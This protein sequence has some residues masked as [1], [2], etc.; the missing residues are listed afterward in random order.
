M[1][2]SAYV[3]II[4]LFGVALGF[5]VISLVTAR[6]A[7]PRRLNKAKLEPYE[8]GIEPTPQPVGGGRVP[9]KYYLTAMLFII[10]DIEV[11]FLVPWAVAA[12]QL[13]LGGFLAVALFIVA[14]TI[15]YIYEWRRGGLEWD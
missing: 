10:F 4:G 8:C 2:L 12:D 11:I 6:I 1:G 13:A 9:V 7:G 5:A 3:P 14:V 15:A